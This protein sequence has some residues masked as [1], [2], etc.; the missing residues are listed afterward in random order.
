MSVKDL[1]RHTGVPGDYMYGY[2]ARSRLRVVAYRIADE[3]DAEWSPKS[4]RKELLEAAF[5]HPALR[6]ELASEFEKCREKV[7]GRLEARLANSSRRSLLKPR[8]G[9]LN[10]RATILEPTNEMET[11]WLAATLAPDIAT[12]WAGFQLL[13]Y[14]PRD[15]IDA[16]VRC[17]LGSLGVVQQHAVEF[18]YEL[19]NF[20]CHAHPIHQVSAIIC[21]T[22]GHL[23]DG[24]QHTSNLGGSSSSD[25]SFT[26]Q[27]SGYC[28][29]LNFGAHVIHV[30]CL[31]EFSRSLGY[32]RV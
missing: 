12:V 2:E 22:A 27:S 11:V 15:G 18:E 6:S 7:V 19:R 21:W 3:S 32:E 26:L 16:V 8:P 23:V 1:A 28:K 25:M 14:T 20:F 31:D 9:Y 10:G 30:L 13:D 17:R 29:T 24:L 5:Q 4:I